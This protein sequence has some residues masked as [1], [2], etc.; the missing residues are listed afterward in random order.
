MEKKTVEAFNLINTY[1]KARKFQEISTDLSQV[2]MYANFQ[3]NNLY[4]IN[5][6]ALDGQSKFDEEKYRVYLK[7]TKNQFDKVDVSQIIL[8]NLLISTNDECGSFDRTP[9]LEEKFVD[10]FWRVDSQ[11][12]QLVI[13]P[14]QIKTVLGFEK[15]I[16]DLLNN[17]QKKIYD[18]Q[19][20]KKYNFAT[21]L[22]MATNLLVWLAVELNGGSMDGDTLYRFGAMQPEAFL[23]GHQYWRLFSSLFLHIGFMHLVVNLFGIYIFGSRLE[24]YTS[25][26]QFVVIYFGAGLMG[27]LISFGLAVLMN[28]MTVLSA[29]ASGAIYGLIGAVLVISRVAGRPIENLT[30]YMLWLYFMI[31]I[32]FSLVDINVSAGAHLGGFIGGLLIAWPMVAMKKKVIK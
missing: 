19:I 14:K 32:I 15:S 30:S 29:G 6:I 27:G 25:T 24:H 3:K 9:N 17:R 13:P 21:Y 12:N 4:L 28:D 7:L 8:L 23:Q 20:V 5:V 1:F 31:G 22:L 26:T 16:R 2:A 10:I 11:T 18:I